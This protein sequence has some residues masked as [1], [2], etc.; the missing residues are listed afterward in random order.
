MN[1]VKDIFYR[2]NDSI[3]YIEHTL[4][5]YNQSKAYYLYHILFHLNDIRVMIK[6]EL[7]RNF[8]VKKIF[9]I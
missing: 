2:Y 6:N 1:I 3:A 8:L 4:L 7:N 5:N 9:N